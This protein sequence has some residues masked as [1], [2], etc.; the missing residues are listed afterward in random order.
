MT[1]L[2]AV[3]AIAVVAVV[4]AEVMTVAKAATTVAKA[5]RNITT[6]VA[7]RMKSKFFKVE[8]FIFLNI[9]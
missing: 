4:A 7:K 8:I 6:V 1:A 5:T 3:V 2:E 9:L